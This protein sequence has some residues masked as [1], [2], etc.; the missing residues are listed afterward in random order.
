M[1]ERGL[2]SIR[3]ATNKAWVLGDGRFK[4]KIE[5][6]AGRQLVHAFGAGRGQEIVGAQAVTLDP[7]ALAYLINEPGRVSVLHGHV[8]S[9]EYDVVWKPWCHTKQWVA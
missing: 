9:L 2:V 3:E 4:A 7:T 8:S 1:P 6:S 5:A